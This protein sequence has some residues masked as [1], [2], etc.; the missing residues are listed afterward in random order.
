M[1]DSLQTQ[2]WFSSGD[3]AESNE[4]PSENFEG[5]SGRSADLV[6]GHEWFR[7]HGEHQSPDYQV[8]IE[9]AIHQ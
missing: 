2:L 7:R 9:I 8:K 3:S 1:A 6:N 4:K 5:R